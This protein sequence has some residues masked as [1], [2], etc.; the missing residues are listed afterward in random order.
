MYLFMR[1]CNRTA[2]RLCVYTNYEDKSR[3]CSATQRF[4]FH[5]GVAQFTST[6]LIRSVQNRGKRLKRPPAESTSLFRILS[7]AFFVPRNVFRRLRASIYH[8]LNFP[9]LTSQFSLRAALASLAISESHF[10]SRNALDLV[11][12]TS[13]YSSRGWWRLQALYAH[14]WD[15]QMWD[16]LPAF[17]CK[18]SRWWFPLF[19]FI[20]EDGTCK[21][22]ARV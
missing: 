20:A 13:F 18:R 10:P 21:L 2:I 5:S 14:L 6:R 9:A 22:H 1:C 3:A 15:P 8:P 16:R 4:W 17:L 7:S 11:Y 12:S 19:A